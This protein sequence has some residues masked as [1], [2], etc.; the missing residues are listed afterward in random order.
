M[1]I[2]KVLRQDCMDCKWFKEHQVNPTDTEDFIAVARYLQILSG[3]HEQL[4]NHRVGR[5]EFRTELKVD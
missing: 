1:E 4:M 3:S 2:V 5:P